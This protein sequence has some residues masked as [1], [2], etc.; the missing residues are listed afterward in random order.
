MYQGGQFVTAAQLND[1]IVKGVSMVADGITAAQSF[2]S[3]STTTVQWPVTQATNSSI[4]T[5]SGTNNTTFTPV[6]AGF[7]LVDT[8][9]RL[10]SGTTGLELSIKVNGVRQSA[11]IGTILAS[12]ARGIR[13]LVGDVITITAIHTTG[14]TKAVEGGAELTSHVSIARLSE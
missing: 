4:I 10:A 1:G 9:L 2:T 7:F 5:I 13:L 12:C 8:A 3:G 14:S 11:G 6:I